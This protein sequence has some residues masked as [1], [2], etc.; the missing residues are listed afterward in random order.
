MTNRNFKVTL[1]QENYVLRI[2]GNGTEGM[3]ERRN[4]EINTLLSYRLGISP[5]IFYF[6]ETTG[7]KLAQFIEGAETL[8]SAIDII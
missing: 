8:N 3:V 5:E 2:P 1:S 4:E 6:N 7:I